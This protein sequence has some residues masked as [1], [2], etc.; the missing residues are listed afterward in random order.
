MSLRHLI[1]AVLIKEPSSGY[2]VAQEFDL[3]AGF[4]WKATHQQVYRELAALAQ[5]G[6]V[7]FT[8][9]EQVG[10]PNKKVYSVTASGVEEFDKWFS[11]PTPIPRS[12]D[13]LLIKF[14]SG[15]DRID[16]LIRQLGYS[17]DEHRQYLASL[18]AVER[19]FYPEPIDQM[20]PWK[21]CIYLSLSLG[22]EREKSWLAWAE[23]SARALASISKKQ[24]RQ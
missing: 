2:Q 8:E 22:I 1:L 23:Q 10:K 21:A 19:E 15:G 12:F 16:E 20:P 7:E 17:V 3:V 6:H 24:G 5:S 4:F 18:E 14:F 11:E 13:P 9:I